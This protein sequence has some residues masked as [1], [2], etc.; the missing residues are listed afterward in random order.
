MKKRVISIFVVLVALTVA[1]TAFAEREGGGGR[2]AGAGAGGGRGGP[3]GAGGFTNL[4]AEERAQMRE[5]YQNM[6][7]EE[8]TKYREQMR[9]RFENMS[10]EDRERLRSGMA[11]RFGSSRY[12]RLSKEDQ[13]KAVKAIQDQLTKLKAAIEGL[14]P[15]YFSS[16]R[17]LSEEDR[18]KLRAKMTK[19]RED[20]QKVMTAI[21]AELAKL[22]GARQPVSRP[23]IS[24]GELTEIRALA[25]KE[26]ATQTTKRIDALIEKQKSQAA[27][28]GFGGS[29]GPGGPGGV[30]GERP[31][32]GGGAG[33]AGRPP[34]EG[35]GGGRPPREG[36][37]TRR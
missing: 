9:A 32:R 30:R 4:S 2:R 18:N 6:S 29:R 31:G 12:S 37:A 3:G 20:R 35:A 17:D 25:T 11:G 22:G 23:Q 8:R 16:F 15:T 5:R 26:K 13:L 34:R 14:S 36:G 28:R 19:D 33:G 24:I 21:E 27:P 1:W 10:A 7:E